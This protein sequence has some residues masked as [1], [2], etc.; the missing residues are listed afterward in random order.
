MTNRFLW[1][2][3]GVV[4]V[5]AV[6][7]RS[8]F[9]QGDG[10]R[11]HWKEMLTD[12]NIFSFTYMHGSGNVNLADPAHIIQP[13]A[14]FEVDLALVGYMRSFALFDRT[15]VVS[16][17]TPVGELEGE[18]AIVSHAIFAGFERAVRE[19]ADLIERRGNS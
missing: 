18:V 13:S 19:M 16:V 10:P 9:A 12:T 17:L 7:A 2:V 6:P 8:A 14:D 3:W 4:L 1:I 11:T 15:A 5:A